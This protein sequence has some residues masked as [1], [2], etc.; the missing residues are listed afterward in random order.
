MLNPD[1]PRFFEERED[2]GNGGL[3]PAVTAVFTLLKK[4]WLIRVQHQ[5]FL[6]LFFSGRTVAAAHFAVDRDGSWLSSPAAGMA[7]ERLI[8][9][10]VLER[11]GRRQHRAV[12]V[13]SDRSSLPGSSSRRSGAGCP[14]AGIAGGRRAEDSGARGAGQRRPVRSDRRLPE[15]RRVA[16]A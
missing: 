4:T 12:G 2:G 9:Y 6:S 16:A 13:P 3:P 8:P 11:E 1:Q 10:F 15:G 14:A 5:S 7:G